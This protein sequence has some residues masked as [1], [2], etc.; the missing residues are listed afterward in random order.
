MSGEKYLYDELTW[1]EIKNRVEDQ[2]AILLPVG[3]VEDHGRHLP[4]KTD[5]F[6]SRN[7]CLATAKRK[8]D[9]VIVMPQIPYGFNKHHSED[10][11]GTIHIEGDTLIEYVLGVTKSVAAHGFNK[12]L[13]I[14][15][16]GSNMPFLDIVARRTVIETDSTCAAFIWPQLIKDL[17]RENRKGATPGGMAHAGELETAFY[18]YVEEESVRKDEMENEIG[19]PESEFFW[20]DLVDSAPGHLMEWWSTFSK[21]GVVGEPKEATKED[22][23]RYF[24]AV[25]DKMVKLVKEFRK[26]DV[27]ER[28]DMH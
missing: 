1:P 15:G 7:I 25:I 17:L 8:P 4:L 13:I 14:D 27:G 2:P 18:L 24:N 20:L 28:K 23:E 19:F 10:F 21:T 9:E 16:H 12:I 11:P 22:G 3:S 6:T 5:N 26:R